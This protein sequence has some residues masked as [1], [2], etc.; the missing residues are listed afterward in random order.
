MDQVKYKFFWNSDSYFSNFYK[1]KFTVNGI[2][3]NCGEQYMMY[4]KAM[5]FGD[6]Q[7][8]NRIM[9]ESSPA[10]Q[11][12]LGREVRKFDYFVWD[13]VKK[14]IVKEGLYHKF[15]Q[16][17]KLKEYLIKHK[18]YVIVESSPYDRIWGI[19]YQEQNA[20]DN[21]NN[22]GQNILGEILT[23]LSQEIN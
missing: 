12:R 13:K 2:T 21:I 3:F 8:A 7:I 16:N 4:K 19:G 23:E 14:D 18:G 20:I 5:L 10:E 6:R 9:N 22:W 11:K 15:T 1:C 17:P